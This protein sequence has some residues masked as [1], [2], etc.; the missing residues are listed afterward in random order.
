MMSTFGRKSVLFSPL[1]FFSPPSP[2]ATA[3]RLGTSTGQGRIISV[4]E[5]EEE[6]P[7]T[8]HKMAL[9]FAVLTKDASHILVTGLN[10]STVKLPP[11]A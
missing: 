6:L 3:P 5:T 10:G 2:D 11:L 9:G 7:K 8:A 4:N 1:T